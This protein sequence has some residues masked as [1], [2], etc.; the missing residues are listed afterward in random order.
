[1]SD[2]RCPSCG[3]TFRIPDFSVPAGATAK[4][5]WC[6]ESLAMSCL[7]V[8]LPPLAE[9]HD[10]HGL[11]ILAATSLMGLSNGV[12][13]AESDVV[14]F[15]S[16]GV[17]AGSNDPDFDVTDFDVTDEELQGESSDAMFGTPLSI[18][19]GDSNAGVMA[20]GMPARSL[21]ARGTRTE[22][23][24]GEGVAFE[25]AGLPEISDEPVEWDS[26]ATLA[27]DDTL[28]TDGETDVDTNG[29]LLL[30]DFE[31][32]GEL[33][34][35]GRFEDDAQEADTQ[36]VDSELSDSSDGET[37]FTE[38][39][40]PRP[41]REVAVMD[42]GSEERHFVTN[43]RVKRRK[44]SP[45][46]TIAGIVI[47]GVAALP[48][49][50]GILAV[51]GKPLDLGFWP[52][53]GQTIAT[54]S[55]RSAASPRVLPPR[56]STRPSGQPGRSLA[57]DIPSLAMGMN[58][59]FNGTIDSQPGP[60]DEPTV[61]PEEQSTGSSV[62]STAS[63]TPSVPPN[64]RSQP[65]IGS[66][67]NDGIQPSTTD[68]SDT[69]MDTDTENTRE[70]DDSDAL[71]PSD[72]AQMDEAIEDAIEDLSDESVVVTGEPTESFAGEN[73]GASGRLD[74]TVA[75][76][77]DPIAGSAADSSATMP[78][79]DVVNSQS[80]VKPSPAVV[81]GSDD[82]LGGVESEPVLPVEPILNAVSPELRM[83]LKTADEAIQATLSHD[84]KADPTGIR[85]RLATLFASVAEVGETASDDN[86]KELRSLVDRLVD[87]GLS[88]DLTPASPN[89]LNFSKRPNDGMFAAGR[90]RR[91]R[92]T[93]LFDWNSTTPLTLRFAPGIEPIPDANV[94]IIGRLLTAEPTP[95]VEVGHIKV[96][97]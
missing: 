53:D 94:L 46:K 16:Q 14:G 12:R 96:I 87:D 88:K 61:K 11:P 69:G 47:G 20:E 84:V 45:M 51:A 35:D 7:L 31:E 9:L 97:D 79:E 26:D 91:N 17:P 42:F 27:I 25:E 64:I 67:Q 56:P 38:S 65:I 85:R 80:Q 71:T 93:W 68:A 2:V 6:G 81:D 30:G 63:T 43:P 57:E 4:C 5:P 23:E 74:E 10:E 15:E 76:T 75:L 40:P 54:G 86:E 73:A 8:H 50:A 49:A 21:L 41:I 29:E 52:F 90:I 28:A 1:M 32:G 22:G 95:T 13:P 3:D 58:D 72:P 83:A 39:V 24:L 37:T 77:E 66:P 60:S 62:T 36:W 59:R 33:Q 82:R 44:P 92:D 55:S 78:A 34:E 89:W 48:L 19:S 18:I 70:L